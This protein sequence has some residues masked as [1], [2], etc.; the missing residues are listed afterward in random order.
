MGD[1]LLAVAVVRR[2]AGAEGLAEVDGLGARRAG[3]GI[4]QIGADHHVPLRARMQK[5]Q[6]RVGLV[7]DQFCLR[8]QA[9]P[10]VVRGQIDHVT[11]DQ[12]IGGNDL[13]GVAAI[14]LFVPI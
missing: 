9:R 2:A 6:L 3:A 10:A 13:G 8:M 14:G 12:R 1:F 5:A 7:L 11:L 4:G